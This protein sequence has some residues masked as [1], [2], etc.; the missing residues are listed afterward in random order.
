MHSSRCRIEPYLDQGGSAALRRT[1]LPAPRSGLRP[2]RTGAPTRSS[3]RPNTPAHPL[4]PIIRRRPA[5]VEGAS[6]CLR[7]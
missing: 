7:R 2:A 6:R 5:P 3:P 4:F 1:A